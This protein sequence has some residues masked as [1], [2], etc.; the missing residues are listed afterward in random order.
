M[1][2]ERMWLEGREQAGGTSAQAVKVTGG[3]L[4]FISGQVGRDRNGN[5]PEGIEAQTRLALDNLKAVLEAAGGTLDNIVKRTIYLKSLSDYPKTREVR[6][7]YFKNPE[8]FPTSTLV[9]VTG[10]IDE[11]LLIEIEAIAVL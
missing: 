11:R 7:Q 6:S 9:V 4:L 5:V 8:T 3:T 1:H 10:M 2:R